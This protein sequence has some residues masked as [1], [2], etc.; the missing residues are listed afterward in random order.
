[1]RKGFCIG[2]FLPPHAGHALLIDTAVAQCDHVTVA[3]CDKPGQ[4]I[5]AALRARWL[6]TEHRDVEVIVVEDVI[7]DDD[8]PGW[9]TYTKSFLGYTPD[10]VF[11]SENYGHAFAAALGCEHVVVDRDRLRIPISGSLIRADPLEYLGWVAPDV[12]AYLVRRVCLIGP[13]S[14]GKT[15]LSKN[16]AAHFAAPFVA[17]YGRAYT[18]WKA[19]TAT[20]DVWHPDEFAH[21]AREQQRR[22]DEAARRAPGI[23]LCDTDAFA[24]EIWLERYLGPGQSQHGWPVRD[25]PMDL[26]LLTD[27]DVPF[28]PDEI[29]DGEHLRPWMFERFRSVLEERGFTYEIL[30][31]PYEQRYRAAKLAIEREMKRAVI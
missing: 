21:I 5:P 19:K 8:S 16:V 7:P 29:R 27:P 3:V 13:E 14:T 28:V 31:G 9:A 30:D 11:T 2:K 10:V 4:P 18:S 26:Y 25:R 22:E 20:P 12:R 23:L 24:T 17:E 1:V 6:R 15:T